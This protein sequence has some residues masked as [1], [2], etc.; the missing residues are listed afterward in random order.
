MF[1]DVSKGP[2][3]HIE[4]SFSSGKA[5]LYPAHFLYNRIAKTRAKFLKLRC[6][7]EWQIQTIRANIR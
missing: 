5:T 1:T 3:H 4:S 6:E 2:M 7:R